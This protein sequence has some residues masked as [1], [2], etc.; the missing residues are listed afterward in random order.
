[1]VRPGRDLGTQLEIV[2]GLSADSQVVTNPGE[3]LTEGAAVK[4]AG[5]E[6]AVASAKGPS[7][8]VSRE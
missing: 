3:M 6:K 7:A 8:R 5:G 4:V 1:V 2:D